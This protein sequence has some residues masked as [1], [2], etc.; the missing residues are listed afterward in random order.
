MLP[1]GDGG[2]DLKMVKPDSFESEL[3]LDMLLAVNQKQ[4]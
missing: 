1:P 3:A 2:A 4:I